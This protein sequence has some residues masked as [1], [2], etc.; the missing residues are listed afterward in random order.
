MDTAQRFEDLIAWQK[1]RQLASEVY[2]ATRKVPFRYD[3]ALVDQVRRASIS[4]ASNIAEGFER[5]ASLAEFSH[6]LTIAKG[7]CA[8]LRAQLYLALDVG[9]LAEDDFQRLFALAEE[10]SRITAGLKSSVERRRAK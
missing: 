9:H 4:V 5:Q 8:E 7:S 6:F 1:A 2:A 10:T 3:R